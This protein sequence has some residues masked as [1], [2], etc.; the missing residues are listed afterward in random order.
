MTPHTA[1]DPLDHESV[2]V[3]V[4]NP[5]D[6]NEPPIAEGDTIDAAA[7]LLEPGTYAAHMLAACTHYATTHAGHL[8]VSEFGA[9]FHCEP[10]CGADTT[11]SDH[12]AVGECGR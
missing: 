11:T 1:C 5:D 10:G 2:H 8:H 12:L 6:V 3:T 4:P 9:V 7:A